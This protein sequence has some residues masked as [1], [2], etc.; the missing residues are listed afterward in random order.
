MTKRVSVG[1]HSKR[2]GAQTL[3]RGLDLLDLVASDPLRFDQLGLAA[4]LRPST[5]Q[6]LARAL[7]GHGFLRRRSDGRLA[8]GAQIL[9]L[10]F[11][12]QEQVGMLPVARA[13]ADQLADRIGIAAFVGCRDGDCSIHLHR[14]VGR[15]RVEVATVAGARRPLAETGLGKALLLD[16]DEASWRRLLALARGDVS[17][18]ESAAW[19]VEMLGHAARG[20]VQHQSSS[21]EN[22]RSIAAPFRDATGAIAGAISVAGALQYLDAGRVREITPLVVDSAAAISRELGYDH[23]ESA[24]PAQEGAAPGVKS[25]NI[26]P[27]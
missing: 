1:S 21:D 6:R 8:L 7:L 10:G 22:I 15:Q 13:Q 9:R 14:A 18:A 27:G 24:R 11:L 5:A 12:A 20:A 16:E 4:G 26:E 19:C 23:D 25:S 2:S 3:D 17:L